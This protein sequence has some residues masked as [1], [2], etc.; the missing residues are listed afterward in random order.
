LA[1]QNELSNLNN[2]YYKNSESAIIVFDVT[3]ADSLEKIKKWVNNLRS[4]ASNDFTIHVVANK[5]D[6]ES[7]CNEEEIKNFCKENSISSY[8]RVS[9]LSGIGINRMI[10]VIASDLLI[11]EISCEIDVNV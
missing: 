4:D 9:A 1:G 2:V 3:E 11:S 5:C 10:S 7:G 8:S 6:L